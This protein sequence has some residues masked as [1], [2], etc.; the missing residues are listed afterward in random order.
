M[1]RL[2]RGP[3]ELD[4]RASAPPRRVPW[5]HDTGFHQGGCQGHERGSVQHIANRSICSSGDKLTAEAW[6]GD[7]DRGTPDSDRHND[8]RI[9]SYYEEQT[10]LGERI[11]G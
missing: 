3:E 4:R 2:P 9:S 5:G 8:G 7:G 1:A 6:Q 11:L 10:D